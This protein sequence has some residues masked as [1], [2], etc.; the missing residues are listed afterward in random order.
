MKNGFFLLSVDEPVLNFSLKS[1]NSAE[2]RCPHLNNRK[3]MRIEEKSGLNT[4]LSRKLG[5][6]RAFARIVRAMAQK[7]D[8]Y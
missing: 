6:P 4:E 7:A 8:N 1:L 2:N 5:M 3:E